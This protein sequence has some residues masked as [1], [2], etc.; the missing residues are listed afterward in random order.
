MSIK[1]KFSKLSIALLSG[2]ALGA[3][4]ITTSGSASADEIYT[5]K[6]GD[7]LSEISYAF[8]LNGD[9]NSIAKANNIADANFITVGQKLVI[10]NDGEIK[11]ATQAEINSLPEVD[12]NNNS[13]N[14][15]NNNTQ[16]QNKQ[17]NNTPA[18]AAKA[19]PKQTAAIAQTGDEASAKEWIAGRESGGSY[20][21]SN[22]QYVGR[23]QLSSSYLNGDYSAANQERVADNY[24]QSRYGSW[25]NAKSFWVANGWY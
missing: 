10:K 11:K 3:A 12:K 24:V 13:N 23:Y 16:Q 5:V 9:Y 25:S 2:A 8:N 6:S 15:N 21:A 17:V 1:S 18:P 20:T 7:T 14:N 19:Q 22:G 4:M